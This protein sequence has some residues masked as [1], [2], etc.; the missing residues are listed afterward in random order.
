MSPGT[1]LPL[2]RPFKARRETTPPP[3]ARGSCRLALQAI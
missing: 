3:A 2:G 1:L